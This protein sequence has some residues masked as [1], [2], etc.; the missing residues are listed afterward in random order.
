MTVLAVDAP[1]E[2]RMRFGLQE[3]PGYQGLFTRRQS[4]LA[5]FGNGARVMK[6]AGGPVSMHA[7]GAT[8]TVLGSIDTVMEGVPVV[9]YFVAFDADPGRAVFISDFK[10]RGAS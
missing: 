4:P 5:L 6:V 10:L 9:G 8:A 1:D 3:H 7:I 2:L